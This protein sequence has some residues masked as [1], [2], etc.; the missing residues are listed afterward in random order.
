M[1]LQNA[2]LIPYHENTHYLIG[3][4]MFFLLPSLYALRN[5]LYKDLFLLLAT[6]LAS[7]AYWYKPMYHSAT[8]KI[9]LLVSNISMV[10]FIRQGILHVRDKNCLRLAYFV[11]SIAIGCFTIS[12]YLHSV[13]HPD[14]WKYHVLF[15]S[16]CTF[17]QQI[18][19]FAKITFRKSKSKTS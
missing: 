2:V 7:T 18:V 9:D 15:H 10:Y 12:S 4:S 19:L 16:C 1:V 8:R 3:S 6:C 11:L 17:G 13:G 14:W 5:A